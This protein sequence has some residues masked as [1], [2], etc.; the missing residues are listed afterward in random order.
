MYEDPVKFAQCPNCSNKT[1]G[2]HVLRCP[3]C[4]KMFCEMCQKIYLANEI[5]PSC[6]KSINPQVVGSIIPNK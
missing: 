6:N 2:Y 5:C 3:N 1:Q 4:G